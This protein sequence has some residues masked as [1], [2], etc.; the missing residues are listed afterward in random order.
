MR[1]RAVSF[2]YID[3]V[4]TAFVRLRERVLRLYV[5]TPVRRE[6]SRQPGMH[7]W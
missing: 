3:N 2:A 7:A 1:L 4:W 5:F 6:G